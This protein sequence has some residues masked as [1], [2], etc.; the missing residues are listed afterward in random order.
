MKEPKCPRCG[1]EMHHIHCNV[2]GYADNGHMYECTECEYQDYI[3]PTRKTMDDKTMDDE[4]IDM[5]AA[6][7]REHADILRAIYCDV[8]EEKWVRNDAF[9]LMGGYQDAAAFVS[10]L[11]E[12]K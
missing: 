9:R 1:A 3:P 11:K 7:L 8:N 6:K 4:T 10:N 12:K 2:L 5:V